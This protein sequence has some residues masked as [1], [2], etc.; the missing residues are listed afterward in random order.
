MPAATDRRSLIVAL[1]FLIV[2]GFCGGSSRGDSLAQIPAR[3]A[4]IGCL[5][6]FLSFYVGPE[7][8]AVFR[9]PILFFLVVVGLFAIQ[10]VPLPPHIWGAVNGRDF[11]AATQQLT[12]L[13]SPWRPLNIAPDLGINAI[14][15]LLP[16]A[17]ALF[18][19]R[20]LATDGQ[21]WML[22]A[23]AALGLAGAILGFIQM[24]QGVD[25]SLRFFQIASLNSPVGF[26]ANRNHHALWLDCTIIAVWAWALVEIDQR[27]R[28]LAPSVLALIA[29][30]VLIFAV[31]TT[32]SRAGM[33]LLLL[34]CVGVYFMIRKSGLNVVSLDRR[35]RFAVIGTTLAALIM[36]VT[37]VTISPQVQSFRRLYSEDIAADAR[38][39]TLSTVL[40]M[41]PRYAPFGSGFGS[42]ERVYRHVET[43]SNLD[44]T[45]LNHAHN[46]VYELLIEGG[47]PTAI[48]LVIFLW[49][50]GRTCW[51]IWVAKRSTR[52]VPSLARAASLITL[53]I[54]AASLPD[55]PIRT[56]FIAV[57]FTICLG[58]MAIGRAALN[59]DRRNV[60]SG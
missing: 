18:L 9:R 32:G 44:F 25:S 52:T 39:Q 38:T 26:F 45:Y 20:G 43:V 53:A 6:A 55:Y 42:F 34:V 23:F 58:W 1:V 7:R 13:S 10:L 37:V 49:W 30:I 60:T 46:D 5:C 48:L 54:M 27:P 31:V 22:R 21:L 19:V 2:L 41:I 12:G 15:S 56:P 50:W 36:I 4:S 47:A 33:V 3:L 51:K 16:V 59:L 8:Q 24:A 40:A 11:Y 17:A 14:L 57:V 29:T 28:A 35:T